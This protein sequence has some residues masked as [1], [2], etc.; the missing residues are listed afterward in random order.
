MSSTTPA[1]G[2]GER[3]EGPAPEPVAAPPDGAPEAAPGRGR[4]PRLI[5][6][7]LFLLILAA[8]LWIRV[9]HNGYGL[10]FVY[11]YD[12]GEHFTN[13]AVEMFGGDLDPGYY[14]NP[15]GYTYLIYAGLRFWFGLL[16]NDL[17]FDQMSLQFRADPTPIW[18]FARTFTALL[19]MAGVAATFF[20]GRALYSARVALVAAALL[21][22]AFLS[23]TYSRIAVTDVGT[24]LPVAVAIWAIV[25]AYER[26]RL[27]HYVVAGAAI[28]FAVGFK[29]TVGL[30]IVPLLIAGGVRYFRDSG[31]PWLKRRDLLFL[32][33]AGAAMTVAFAITTPYFF[34]HPHDALYQLKEQAQ[35]AGDSVKLGQEQ[36]G[37]LIYYLKSF[38]WG[39]GWAA[40]AAA[41]VGLVL[42]FRR[43]RMRAILLLSFP[44]V[45]YLY[46]GTQT[47]YFGRWLLMIYPI[48]AILAGIGIV[49]TAELVR[50]RAGRHGWALSGAL[51]AVITALVL[52]QPVTA[53]IRTSNVLGREDTRQLARDWLTAHYPKSLRIVIEPAVP[54]NY[55][56]PTG[57]VNPK[58]NIFVRGYVTDLRR[59]QAFDAPEG[60]DTTYAATLSPANL[61]GYRAQGFCLVMTNSLIRGR[62]EN[63]Q[64]PQA[65]AYY[66]RLERESTHLLRI[67]PFDPGRKPVPLHYDFSY[68]YYPTAYS[69]PGGIIDIYRLNDCKQQ[70]GRVPSRPYG[71]SGLEK[72]VETSL[73]PK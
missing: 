8:G 11:N 36:E 72:G 30:A 15:S 54:D 62:A 2:T 35:A 52:I 32:V 9:R 66:Q 56:R 47:R 49:R 6:A 24:F 18:E 43:D 27:V 51:A 60:V 19:A 3:A 41:L 25:R 53:D 26:G 20:V 5:V 46:M 48:L 38:T 22:F 64:V 16:P 37:G 4:G 10:P 73:P 65:L 61:D 28:G 71:V 42:E 57:K 33:A 59:Q 23:V 44:V 45:L 12:E 14:Q 67:S 13:R 70:T 69:R 31:T 58:R 50:G 17:R 1:V 29:Y 34:V 63:A 55:Y 39:F 40:I 21:A 7:G 68:N